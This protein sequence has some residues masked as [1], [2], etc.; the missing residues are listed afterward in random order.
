MNKFVCLECGHIFDEEDIA[1]WQED[2]GEYGGTPCY[3]EM[4]GCPKCAGDY[5]ET[6]KCNCCGEWIDGPYIKLENDTRI[7]QYCYTTYELGEEL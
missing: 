3:E 2:R 7:C 6:Y 4:S 1:T 5:A